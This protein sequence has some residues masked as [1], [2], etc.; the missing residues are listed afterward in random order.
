MSW[1]TKAGIGVSKLSEI[2]IDANKDW[3]AKEIQNLKAI[4]AGMV[5]GDIA[6]RGPSVLEKLAGE[7]GV[8]YNFLHM[9][10]TGAFTPEWRD[11]QD[12]VA[13]LTGAVNRMIAPPRLQIPVPTCNVETAEEHSGGG[14]TAE[15]TRSIPVPTVSEAAAA[16]AGGNVVAGARAYDHS[17]P[18]YTDE[19][20]E[21]NDATANDVTLLPA[22]PA[23]NDA[24]YFGYASAWDWLNLNIGTAGAGTWTITWEYW[25]G[26]SWAA[27]SGV[28]DTSN[29]FRASGMNSVKF[30]RPYD[31]A[32]HDVDGT[33]LYWI[34]GRVT[35]YSSVTTQPLGTQAWIGAWP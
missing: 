28:H 22:T 17:G 2:E 21:V 24:Y 1:L 14:Y 18:T 29:G 9:Q 10:N 35:S 8:G 27:L 4:V 31:W 26:S 20:T 16:Q 12:I 25:N 13:Y 23:V 30:N 34:R 6:Y 11:I 7:Y 15:N 3:Q 32:N 33:T 19:T 5:E